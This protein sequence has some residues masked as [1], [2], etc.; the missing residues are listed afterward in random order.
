[1]SL[2]IEDTEGVLVSA[3]QTSD[4]IRNE[5]LPRVHKTLGYIN[6]VL[7]LIAFYIV[8]CTVKKV[9]SKK[10]DRKQEQQ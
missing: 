9:T 10:E 5:T 2:P 6:I 7:G 3:K 8:A 4:K 1:M